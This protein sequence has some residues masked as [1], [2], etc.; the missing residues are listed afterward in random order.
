M[1][2][3]M[4]EEAN[5]NSSTKWNVRKVRSIHGQSVFFCRECQADVQVAEHVTGTTVEDDFTI[6]WD[7]VNG[8]CGHC[9]KDWSH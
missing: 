3:S 5:P 2:L 9:V 8:T 6:Y 7:F 4:N 1:Q